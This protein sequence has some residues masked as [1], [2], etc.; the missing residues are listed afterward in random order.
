[1]VLRVTD[2]QCPRRL[3][4]CASLL[5][6]STKPTARLSSCF[7]ASRTGHH[8]ERC[9]NGSIIALGHL[10]GTAHALTVA[11]CLYLIC[12]SKGP[13]RTLQSAFSP[14]SLNSNLQSLRISDTPGI[15]KL[16]ETYHPSE[17][18]VRC[19]IHRTN[20]FTTYILFTIQFSPP[21]YSLHRHAPKPNPTNF[22]YCRD[23]THLL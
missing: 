23:L 20:P 3:R 15:S 17:V 19:D 21:N 10:P 16:R 9:N 12:E 14:T 7:H 5:W 2:R 13:L 6:A 4:R 18:R 8:G 1:M 22:R 11:R